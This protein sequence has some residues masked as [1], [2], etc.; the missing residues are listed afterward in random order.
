MA[1]TPAETGQLAKLL[2]GTLSEDDLKAV[3]AESTG[4]ELYVHWVGDGKPLEQTVR[5]L[6]NATER[7]GITLQVASEVYRQRPNRRDV[8]LHLALLYPEIIDLATRSAP[9]FDLQNHG[10]PGPEVTQGAF[11]PGLQRNIKARLPQ[12]DIGAWTFNL[13]HVQRRVCRIEISGAAVG[14]GFLVGPEA[15]LTNWHVVEKAVAQRSLANVL[16]RFD[17]AERPDGAREDGL[18]VGLH[19]D[20]VLHHRPYA[21]AEAT[22]TPDTPP[23]AA[24]E[25]DFALLRLNRRIGEDA[26]GGEPRGFIAL[27]EAE[28]LLATGDPVI[29]V[30]HPDGGPMKLAIDTEA[31]LDLPPPPGRPRIRYATNT[32]AG[33][34]GS[35]CLTIDWKLVALHHF[36]DPAWGTPTFNQGVPAHLIRADIV[37]A[38][39]GVYLS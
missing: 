22:T 17:Y 2:A 1:L 5:D 15:V 20:G 12:L 7:E 4:D 10:L 27:P 19:G 11:A 24:T 39:F 23:P 14:T 34:S 28:V 29:I 21:P 3:V 13:V 30:Q 36:G 6:I 35:P 16:C 33:S 31:A 9:A 18:R 25:L 32:A 37:T 8:R 26:L 38:G